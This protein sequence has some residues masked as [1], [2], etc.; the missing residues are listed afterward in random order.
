MKYNFVRKI[1]YALLSLLILSTL[2]SLISVI[3]I[4]TSFKV[5][6]SD[7]A[8]DI[9]S[10]CI[11]LIPLT[12]LT[13][14]VFSYIFHRCSKCH[15]HM[16]KIFNS[17]CPICHHTNIDNDNIDLFINSNSRFF[18]MF[19]LELN[20][21]LRFILFSAIATIVFIYAYQ[22]HLIYKKA[23]IIKQYKIDL[24][25]EI[26]DKMEF[27]KRINKIVQVV[28]SN[29][30][31]YDN[32]LILFK[33]NDWVLFKV[34]G[35]HSNDSLGPIWVGICSDSTFITSDYPTCFS[36]IS[37]PILGL[38]QPNSFTHFSLMPRPSVVA[39]F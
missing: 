18:K 17:Q 3:S 34:H 29:K 25:N 6:P 39:L 24:T 1:L 31:W 28:Q 13:A 35:H 26:G 32:N 9:I 38:N 10:N 12:I 22:Q 2:L 7:Y 5:I 23:I 27:S 11:M 14:S 21:L 16:K 15:S 33:D 20:N 36:N 37:F 4:S 8:P 30:Y 19:K